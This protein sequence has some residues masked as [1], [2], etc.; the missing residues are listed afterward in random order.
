MPEYRGDH[1]MK[2]ILILGGSYQHKK[3]VNAAREMGLRTYVTDYNPI[4][5]SPAKQLAD[6]ALDLDIWDIGGI[7]DFCEKEG[8]SAVVGP[9]LDPV[10][11]PYQRICEALGL[12]CFGNAEQTEIYTD[13][14]RFKSEC[15]RVGLGVIPEYTLEQ[16]LSPEFSDFPILIKPQNSRGSRGQR[17]CVDRKSVLKV[18]E[19]QQSDDFIIEKYMSREGDTGISYLVIDGEPYFVRTEDRCL[20]SEENGLERLAVEQNFPSER[21]ACLSEQIDSAIRNFIKSTGLRNAPV[22]LQAFLRGGQIY[23]YDPGLRMPGDEFDV[24]LKELT[25]IDLPKEFVTFAIEGRFSEGLADSLKKCLEPQERRACLVM[26]CVRAGT[27]TRVDGWDKIVSMPQVLAANRLHELGEQI[28]KTGDVRQRFCEFLLCGD[29]LELET[30][31]KIIYRLLHVY[32]ENGE[33][34]LIENGQM[35]TKEESL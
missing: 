6:L 2:K 34:L 33:E 8:I 9:Y 21:F 14:T 5:K 32:D 29:R 16:V 28:G 10:Q 4:K 7:V 35:I 25:G 1:V 12:P 18:L 30:A 3:V 17:V 31:T 27:I 20:G 13:K 23:A 11:R 22:M 26:P 15:R 19:A 24:G